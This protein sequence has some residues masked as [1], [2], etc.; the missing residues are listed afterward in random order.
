MISI[1]R[2]HSFIY[3]F[4]TR[5]SFLELEQENG[6]SWKVRCHKTMAIYFEMALNI[7]RKIEVRNRNTNLLMTKLAS[8]LK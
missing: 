4:V 6:E 3:L 2:I 1:I 5:A 7:N 8:W